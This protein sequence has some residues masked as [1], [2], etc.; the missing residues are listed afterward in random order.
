MFEQVGDPEGLSET[1][2]LDEDG[3]HWGRLI[4]ARSEREDEPGP[5]FCPPRPIEPAHFDHLAQDLRAAGAHAA[6]GQAEELVGAVA[7]F[8]YSFVRLHAFHCA[9]QCLTMSLVNRLLTQTHGAGIPHL[10]LD[11]LA[12]RLSRPAFVRVFRRAVDAYLVVDDSPA[13]RLNILQQR[14]QRAFDL[15]E[16]V[17]DCATD[18]DVAALCADDPEAAGWALLAGA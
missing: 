4:T 11:H 16:R 14:K 3:L 17:G 1:R 8:H 15:I 12:L 10:V 18:E 7:S 5:W 9:N 2:T 6:Q 13:R